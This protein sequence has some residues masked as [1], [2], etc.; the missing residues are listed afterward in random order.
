MECVYQQFTVEKQK[1]RSAKL[2]CMKLHY[3]LS[4]IWLK[5]RDFHA[6]TLSVALLFL[7]V[8]LTSQ[9]G[10]HSSK[11]CCIALIGKVPNGQT[12][13]KLQLASPIKFFFLIRQFNRQRKKKCFSFCCWI[14]WNSI[15]RGRH[16]VLG[17]SCLHLTG[18]W[19]ASQRIV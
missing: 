8:Y 13:K 19:M 17:N 14:F 3:K 5:A 11:L 6:S 1:S 12:K 2:K 10:F 18:S 9:K 16:Y 15:S 7:H 4:V